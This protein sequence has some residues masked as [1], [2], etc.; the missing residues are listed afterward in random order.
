MIQKDKRLVTLLLIFTVLG[1]LSIVMQEGYTALAQGDQPFPSFPVSPVPIPSLPVPF[2]HPFP[3]STPTPTLTAT[4]TPVPSVK[5]S[6]TP[7][8]T[9]TNLY[10]TITNSNGTQMAGVL[11]LVKN[12]SGAQY[13]STSDNAGYYMICHVPFGNYTIA[14]IWNNTTAKS[15]NLVMNHSTQKLNVTLPVKT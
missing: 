1:A 5:P 14:F 4:P 13:S 11:A 3:S 2:P 10:G 6:P 15:M 7:A 8:P 12:S 9:A